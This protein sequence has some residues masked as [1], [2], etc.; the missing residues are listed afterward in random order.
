MISNLAYVHP[1][2]KLG[3]GVI[4][5]PF[6]YIQAGAVIG[7]GTWVGP[8]ASV[9][10]GATVGKNCKIH[11]G[12]VVGGDPQDL[13][14]QGETT[15]CIVGDNTT[16][17]ECCTI[18]RGTAAKGITT[19]GSNCLLMAY[20]HVGHDCVVG[21]YVV[22]VNRVSLAGEV[23]VGD[24][25]IVGG[26]TGVHQFTRIGTHSMVAAGSRLGRDVTPFIKV[27]HE[28]SA[29][30]GLN[31]IGLRR[32]GFSADQI[33]YIQELYRIMF[34]S[35]LSVT[36]AVN[37]ITEEI[38]DGETKALILDFISSSK[39]GLIKPYQAKFKDTDFNL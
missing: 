24:W 14:Y 25:A 9:M 38:E 1:D 11:S 19:V 35:G 39:R 23:E 7:D 10:T 20:V 22:L 21:D 4:V 3:D 27:A 2:A 28:P 29:Y 34:Q 33:G 31:S 16:I 6:A 12:A 37:K 13:K 36:N 30:V 26:H 8:H 32:R 18:N 17:R 5:E 15:T